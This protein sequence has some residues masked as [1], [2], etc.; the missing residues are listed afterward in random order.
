MIIYIAAL[1]G[2][3][4]QIREAAA[5]DGANGLQAFYRITL[6]MILPAI[7][8]GVAISL[9]SSFKVFDVVYALTG[10]GPGRATQVIAL[11]IFE[12]AFHRHYRYGYASAKAM[13]LFVM[14]GLVTLV[15]LKVMKKREVEA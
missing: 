13:I 3:P 1:Q 15:Q 2:V 11:N 8:V 6:P 7:T 10:G 4:R 12:E 5:I 14:V 9:S